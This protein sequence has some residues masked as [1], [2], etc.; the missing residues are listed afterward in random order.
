MLLA[1]PDSSGS[2]HGSFRLPA[3]I[4][5]VSVVLMLGGCL[6][7]P[8]GDEVR[9]KLPVATRD[10]PAAESSLSPEVL[11]KLLVAEFAGRRGDLSLAF[12]NYLAVARETGDPQAAEQAVRIATFARDYEK[13][14]EA[15]ALWT[16]LAPEDPEAVQ[17]H[18]IL[19]IRAGAPEKAAEVLR[20]LI[21]AVEEDSPGQGL[22]LAGEILSREH[23]R[24][25]AIRIMEMLVADRPEDPRAQFALGHLLARG[26][27]LERAR[28]AF[29]RVLEAEPGNEQAIVLLA[30]LHQQRGDVPRALTVL[31]RALATLPEARI[32]R[33]SYARLLVEAQRFDEGRKQ[34]ERLVNED[35][36][37]EDV[38]YALAL[39]LLQTKAYERA[40]QEFRT[41]TQGIERRDTAYFHLGEI[42]EIRGDGEAAIASYSRV[43]QADNRLS[44][45]LR[46]AVLLSEAGRLEEARARLHALS[47]RSA[48]ESVRLYRVE[49]DLLAHHS[50]LD[51][52]MQVLNAAIEEFPGDGEL[53]YARA[54]LAEQLDDL[55]LLERD[56]KRILESAPDNADALN[57]L[58]YTLADRTDRIDE[59][60]RLVKRAYE[61][62]PDSHY[63]VDSMGW[64][65]FRMGRYQEALR[66]LRQAMELGPDPEIAAHLGE[67]LWAIGNEEEARE[68]WGSALEAAPEDEH[69]LD[70]KKRFG[71]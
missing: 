45:Q 61:L 49:A 64:V 6:G 4:G 71:L 23:D 57:A 17:I 36:G 50:R 28:I 69:L 25:S 7:V 42:A 2:H 37:D 65:M 63:I 16:G 29:E 19:L 30:R 8:A 51:E 35:P 18:A 53:L 1:R 13:G 48:R 62:R 3:G 60:Y 38:R 33:L 54:M 70:V 15:V 20:G 34:F 32:V 66:F 31:E 27:E 56:L 26:D 52:A 41:L 39:L 5:W 21:A 44:A 47:G 58:G 55:A 9:A 67:V 59:A 12:D 22:H 11:Y 68:V 46:V 14:L 43:Q 24:A 10:E 40:E